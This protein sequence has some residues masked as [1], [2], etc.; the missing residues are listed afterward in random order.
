MITR[1]AIPE[2]SLDTRDFSAV[3][4]PTQGM[5]DHQRC[6][7]QMCIPFR[8]HSYKH[9]AAT[10]ACRWKQLVSMEIAHKAVL[11]V[12]VCFLLLIFFGQNSP[13]LYLLRAFY[14]YP[15]S[16]FPLCIEP[17]Q[18][19]RYSDWLRAGWPRCRSS[20][21]GRDKIFSST[22]CRPALGPTQPPIQWV[23]R[24]SSPG[25]KATGA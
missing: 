6:F 16:R 17:G 25:V 23:L 22:S 3:R 11:Y 4:L 20:S 10:C 12:C 7:R 14:F 18:L 24:T 9:G 2:I 13:F 21:P 15:L 5:T 8:R 1:S 19:S